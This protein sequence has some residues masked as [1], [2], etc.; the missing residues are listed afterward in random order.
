MSQD[1]PM[2]H[3]IPRRRFLRNTGLVA[4]GMLAARPLSVLAKDPGPGAG[5]R[6]AGIGV[7]GMGGANIRACAASGAPG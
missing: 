7:G 5:L 4:A 2:H 1:Y 6:V 3:P